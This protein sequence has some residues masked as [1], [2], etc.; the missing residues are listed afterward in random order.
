MIVSRAAERDGHTICAETA[1]IAITR[2]TAI[3]TIQL[4]AKE[5][6]FTEET[7]DAEEREGTE[8][9]LFFVERTM[10]KERKKRM[11]RTRKRIRQ[12]R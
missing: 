5:A 9:A 4:E 7:A 1:S 12:E 2:N 3:R 10:Q 11:R 8:E 6:F